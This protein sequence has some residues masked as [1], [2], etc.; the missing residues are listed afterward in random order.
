MKQD[1][2]RNLARPYDWIYEPSERIMRRI[3]LQVFP[4]G[5]NLSILDVGCGTGTQ[6]ALY[7][8]AGSN[9]YGV[10]TSPAML[11]IARRKLGENADL[12][13]EDACHMTFADHM[14]DLVTVV[15][16]LHEMPAAIRPAVLTECRRVLGSDGRVM[17]IDYDFGPYTFPIS[18]IWRALRT[19][20]EIS[21]GRQHYANYREFRTHG[22]LEPL[23]TEEKFSVD[24]R[25]SSKHGIATVYLL[26]L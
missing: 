9:L 12:R 15:F 21:A 2:Y 3:G 20:M 5:D 6:L 4:P 11:A 24:K 7:R 8:R 14:F 1:H 22:G 16:V 26:K 18:I 19:M 13:L 17:L 10:D 23:I 25:V